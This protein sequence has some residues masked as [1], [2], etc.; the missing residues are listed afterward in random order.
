[1]NMEGTPARQRA[2]KELAGEREWIADAGDTA[3]AQ[4]ALLARMG[5]EYRSIQKEII[6]LETKLHRGNEL[7]ATQA[8]S[9]HYDAYIAAGRELA[10]KITGLTTKKEKIA[11]DIQAHNGNPDHYLVQ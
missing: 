6:D 2:S 3:E 8:G 7:A 4:E 11:S 5:E 1:M 10:S 9:K